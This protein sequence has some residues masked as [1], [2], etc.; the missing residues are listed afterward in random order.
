MVLALEIRQTV[1]S[2]WSQRNMYCLRDWFKDR[3]GIV[4]DVL[5]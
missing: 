2:G 4:R 5:K 3:T 1:L